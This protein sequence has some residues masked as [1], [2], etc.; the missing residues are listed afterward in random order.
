METNKL[1][2]YCFKQELSREDYGS[3]T[4]VENRAKCVFA[5]NK[6]EAKEILKKELTENWFDLI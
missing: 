6:K 3:I 4:F 5:K 1:K 2:K